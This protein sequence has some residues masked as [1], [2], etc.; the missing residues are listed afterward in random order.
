MLVKTND[1]DPIEAV[2]VINEH[3]SSFGNDDLV[4][5]V[6]GDAET[7]SDTGHGEML[8]HNSFQRPAQPTAGELRPRLDHFRGFLAPH[9]PVPGAIV[10][11]DTHQQCGGALAEGFLTKFSRHSIVWEALASAPVTPVIRS[12]NTTRKIRADILPGHLESK[13]IKT[14][15]SSRVGALKGS[16]E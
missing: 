1:F 13:A 12:N 8:A 11:A 4:R 15:K 9:V 5:G 10:A 3:T 6:P 16:V 2:W 7:F 14:A